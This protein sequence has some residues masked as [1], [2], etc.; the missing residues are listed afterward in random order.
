[1]QCFQ[2]PARSQQRRDSAGKVLAEKSKVD[3]TMAGDETGGRVAGTPNK[4]TQARAALAAHAAKNAD[5]STPLSVMLA[6]IDAA[7]DA[8]D[9]ALAL[10]SSKLGPLDTRNRL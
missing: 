6:C 10:A 2:A 3:I 1:L 8:G 9:H 5:L 7:L 4:R